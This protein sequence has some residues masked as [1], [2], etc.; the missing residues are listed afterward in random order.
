MP[1]M[2]LSAPIVIGA[3]LAGCL[4]IPAVSARAQTQVFS[5]TIRDHKFDP[6]ELEVPAGQKI[7]LR[8][9]NLDPTP[10]EFESTSLRREKVIPGGQQTTILIGPLAAGRYEFF[11]EFHP[12]TTRGA[13]IAK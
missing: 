12:K 4:L 1:S 3:L 6:V 5:L 11:G 2:K 13:V 8:V 7:E 10:E 9:K